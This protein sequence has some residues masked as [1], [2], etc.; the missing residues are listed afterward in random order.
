MNKISPVGT[1]VFDGGEYYV[2]E[3]VSKPDGIMVRSASLHEM[4]F[5]PEL[6]GIARAG[7]GVNQYSDRSLL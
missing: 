2:S 5:N 3:T 7:A 6:L 1:T 4:E